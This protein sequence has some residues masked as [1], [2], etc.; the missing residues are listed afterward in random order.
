MNS[1]S[2]LTW[3]SE[4][5]RNEMNEIKYSVPAMTVTQC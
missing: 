2:D 4:A 3:K 5:V 1:K